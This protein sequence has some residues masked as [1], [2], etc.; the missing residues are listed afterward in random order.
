MLLCALTSV[1]VGFGVWDFVTD[2]RRSVLPLTLGIGV[3][4]A[5]YALMTTLAGLPEAKLALQRVGLSRS[6]S[7]GGTG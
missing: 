5:L 4:I 6:Q 2:D 1:G 7:A 3:A